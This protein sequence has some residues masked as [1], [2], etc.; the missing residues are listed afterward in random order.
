MSV[1]HAPREALLAEMDAGLARLLVTLDGLDDVAMAGLAD[2]AGWTVKDH[3][4]H[5]AVWAGS[6][7]AVL[8]RAPRWERMGVS[9]DVWR[10]IDEGYDAIND[11]IW[12]GHRHL[13][14][15]EARAL[16]EREH[17]ALEERVRTMTDAA[18]ATPYRELQPWADDETAPVSACILGNTADHYDEHRAYIQAILAGPGSWQGGGR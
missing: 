16:L 1:P 3:V 18:L 13:T 4:A 14:G 2:E 17:R 11:V 8:D 15:A 12:H 7:L 9:E 5:L 6:L 10:T